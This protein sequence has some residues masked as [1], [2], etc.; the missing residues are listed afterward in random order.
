MVAVDIVKYCRMDLFIIIIAPVVTI[1]AP[2]ASDD[3]LLYL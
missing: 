2:L 3:Y 1:F